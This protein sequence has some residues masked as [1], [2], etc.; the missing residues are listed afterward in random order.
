MEK[1]THCPSTLAAEFDTYSPVALKHLFDKQKISHILPYNSPNKDEVSA[2]LFAENLKQFALPGTQFKYSLN[3]ENNILTLTPPSKKGHYILK[4]IPK[5]IQ[6]SLEY[7]ANENLTMQIARQV[8]KIETVVNGLCFFKDGEPAYLTKRFDIAGKENKHRTDD[9]ATLAGISPL[10]SGN[11]YKYEQLSYEEAALLIKEFVPAWRVE[12]LKF[13]RLLLFNFLFSN[14]N[15]HLKKLS[16][17]DTPDGDFRLAP[18]YGL[19][20]TR[21]HGNEVEFALEKG[22]FKD[23]DRKLFK[24]GAW[25]IGATF[26]AF[27]LKIGLQEKVV[28]KELHFFRSWHTAIEE[29]VN[30]SFL[31]ESIKKVYFAQYRLRRR[32]LIDMEL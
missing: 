11:N 12:I 8:F 28:D 24:G 5:E 15:L 18:A 1:P 4:P 6:N 20:N 23:T 13:Y 19:I 14:G 27:G 17:M 30:N 7:A 32:R 3:I 22:L 21:I 16:L 2:K 25:A 26:R 9:F 31:S 29:L 10:N